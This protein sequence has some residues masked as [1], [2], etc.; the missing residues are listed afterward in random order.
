MSTAV[1]R[2]QDAWPCRPIGDPG[3]QGR[4]FVL[5]EGVVLSGERRNRE[6]SDGFENRS[7]GWFS[8]RKPL[9]PVKPGGRP[10]PQVGGPLDR[11]CRSSSWKR[12]TAQLHRRCLQRLCPVCKSITASRLSPRVSANTLFSVQH[13]NGLLACFIRGLTYRLARVPPALPGTAERV[14]RNVPYAVN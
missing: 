14:A 12:T 11:C 4:R 2:D 10:G 6:P 5:C 13:A 3:S 9:S 8:P 7:L 1:H